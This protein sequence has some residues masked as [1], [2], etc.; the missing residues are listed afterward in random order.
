MVFHTPDSCLEVFNLNDTT[1]FWKI[2]DTTRIFVCKDSCLFWSLT[3]NPGTWQVSQNTKGWIVDT[4]I[5]IWQVDK[6][7]QLWHFDDNKME[8]NRTKFKK[9]WV[10]DD[11]IS[12]W[13]INSTA[14]L[15]IIDDSL[16]IWKVGKQYPIWS[17]D[18]TTKVWIYPKKKIEKKQEVPDTIVYVPIVKKK[19]R[20]NE[21]NN[22]MKIW[23]INDTTKIWQINNRLEL[24]QTEPRAKL[25]VINDTTKVWNI[26][27]HYKISV[28]NDSIKIWTKNDSTFVWEP[29]K[30]Y[31]TV[32]FESFSGLKKTSNKRNKTEQYDIKGEITKIDDTLKIAFL[33]DTIQVWNVNSGLKMNSISLENSRQN[34]EIEDSLNV[35][36]IDDTTQLFIFRQK[37]LEEVWYF[38]KRSNVLPINDSTGFLQVN[39]RTRIFLM[40]GEVNFWQLNLKTPSM[41]WRIN[42][43]LQSVDFNDS[44]K[45]WT[46]D[47]TTKIWQEK[48]KLSLYRLDK[49]AEVYTIND[50]TKAWTYKKTPPPKHKKK[51]KYWDF[52]G[53]GN[54]NFNQGY[55]SHWVKGGENTA[56]TTAMLKM[57]ANWKKKNIQWENDGE[58]HF[59]VIKQQERLLRKNEDKIELNVKIGYQFYN[60]WYYSTFSSFKSQ[61]TTGYDKYPND[62]IIISDFMAPAI[63]TIGLGFDYKPNKNF[64]L[65]ISPI[66]SISTYVLDTTKVDPTKHGLENDQT[67]KNEKGAYVRSKIKFDLTKDILIE[68][69]L[70]LFTNYSNKPE[71]IDVNWQFALA[72]KVNKY[73]NTNINTHLIYDDDIKVPIY[74]KDPQ[75][76]EDVEIKKGPRVQFKEI[77]SIGFSY[78]F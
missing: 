64:S 16:Q 45:M 14:F 77:L 52:G 32:Y 13:Q 3:Q 61:F 29:R 5:E 49:N 8:W 46:L 60:Y 65:V 38:D 27:P 75:T 58:F 56:A 59:G 47:D 48:L 57:S 18:D 26:E 37:N 40:N 50:S 6:K 11:S 68:N 53:T 70:D 72:M 44:L 15:R 33:N 41:G 2:N 10:L 63:L 17:I 23:S 34:I 4:D 62:T 42:D 30:K 54:I 74:E 12:E 39:R 19:A 21:I 36:N 69:T 78:K 66:T 1:A 22:L 7:T 31:E 71:N 76:G 73:I 43:T 25:W 35:W 20:L 55:Y 67:R 24:W 51:I 28:I 9:K